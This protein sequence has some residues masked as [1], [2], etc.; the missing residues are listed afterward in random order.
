MSPGL[1][2]AIALLAMVAPMLHLA[3]DMMEW[4]T[5][6]FSRA[7]LLINYAGFLPMPF[8][9][10][11]L[12]AVQRPRVNWTGLVG[13]VLYGVAFIYF[14]HTT[15]YSLQESIPD[16]ETLWAKLGWV[17]TLHGVFMVAGGL[18]FG[19]ASLQARVLWRPGIVLFLLG[20]LI[21]LLLGLMPLPEI[22][23][24]AGSTIRNAGLIGIGAALLFSRENRLNS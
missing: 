5:G 22:L 24:I 16:Y 14:V 18:L 6:G 3:S 13:A 7:Q 2:R 21:N 17:Y 9:I 1:Y 15:L 12:Y 20:I 11:G 23:Q 8:M 10:I 4:S 19:F